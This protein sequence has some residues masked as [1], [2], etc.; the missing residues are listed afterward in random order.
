MQTATLT[1]K[2]AKFVAEYLVDGNGS[3]AAVR[4]GY[5]AIGAKVT[6][7]R[8]LTNPNLRARLEAR[9]SADATRLSAG[10]QG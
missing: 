10:P 1:P 8:L 9:Q 5:G 4:A 2:Q 7:C 6:A 3:A